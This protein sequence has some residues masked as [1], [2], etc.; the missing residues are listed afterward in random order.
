[1]TQETQQEAQPQATIIRGPGGR[2]LPG[3]RSPKPITSEN[4]RDYA[5][6]RREKQA[7]L[8]RAAITDETG[9]VMRIP[10][11]SSAAAVAAAGGMLWAQVVL[12]DQAYPRD[13]L[14]AWERIGRH[15]EILGDPRQAQDAAQ[16]VVPV[17]DVVSVLA[18]VFR[19]VMQARRGDVV[20][21][22]VVAQVQA[23]E[24]V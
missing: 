6:M 4:T 23:D 14:D 13:R 18:S 7:R 5:R 8:L 15:A 20:E 17:S 22:A 2:F 1:M 9:A 3:T 12:N 19:D 16:A 24:D 21:G 11:G 10:A